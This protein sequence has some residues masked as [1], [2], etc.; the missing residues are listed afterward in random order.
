MKNILTLLCAALCLN[1][2]FAQKNVQLN[3]NHLIGSE[4]LELAKEY[5]MDGENTFPY[6]INRLQYYVSEITLIHD[7]GQKTNV[8]DTWLL[9]T[10]PETSTFDLGTFN[11]DNIEGIEYHLGV[12]DEANFLDPSS[13][14]DEHP[15]ANKSPSMHWGWAAG[16]RFAA[17]EGFSGNN[18]LLEYQI[19]SLGKANYKKVALSLNGVTT[20]DQ[21][22]ITVDADYENI[23]SNIN[24]SKLVFL[25]GFDGFAADLM[26]IL[27]KNV[28]S[29]A[30]TSN[31]VDEKYK[32][33]KFIK[34]NL[35]SDN[36]LRI[37]N[38]D[39]SD[40]SVLISNIQ[41]Q[42]IASQNISS[43]DEINIDQSGIFLCQFIKNGVIV[44]TEKVVVR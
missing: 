24:F 15:L 42:I 26:N 11:I 37:N 21:I 16:Y 7:G 40:Y 14:P 39:N 10:V 8:A 27:G 30:V 6:K 3:I 1:L 32:N 20:N 25:H 18:F 28:F 5:M 38:L 29:A 19:H 23:Y 33:Y 43:N 31:T 41:G 17:L 13:Y 35:L 36:T 9:V 34:N 44:K 22:D 12:N 4:E 2:S